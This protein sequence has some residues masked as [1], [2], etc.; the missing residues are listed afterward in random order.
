MLSG[1]SNFAARDFRAEDCEKPHPSLLVSFASCRLARPAWDD[2][3]KLDYHI[4]PGKHGLNLADWTAYMD[5]A[6]RQGWR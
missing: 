5:F 1:A 2:P 6:E 4:R 3:A